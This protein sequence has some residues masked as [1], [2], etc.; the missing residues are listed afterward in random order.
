MFV[1]SPG[2]HYLAAKLVPP[3]GSLNKNVFG[4]WDVKA[5]ITSGRLDCY[6]YN[7]N[8]RIIVSKDGITHSVRTNGICK[9]AFSFDN[10][11]S[12]CPMKI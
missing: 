12:L 8:P 3:G 6:D 2:S 5:Q 10:C 4:V 1:F 9:V 7:G 11:F